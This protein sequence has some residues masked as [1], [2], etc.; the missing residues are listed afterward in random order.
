MGGV[1]AYIIYPDR[2]LRDLARVLPDDD[3]AL[4]KVRGIG[5]AKAAS[6]GSE[7]LAVIRAATKRT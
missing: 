3:A 5:P 7:T 6:Y 4:R 2:T 1:P